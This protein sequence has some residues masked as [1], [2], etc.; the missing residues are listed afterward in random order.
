MKDSG[1]LSRLDPDALI[2]DAAALLRVP[3]VPAT[4]GRCSSGS[5]SWR[6]AGL[7][8]DLH[9][10]DLAAL[11]A[12]PD[13]PGE[14][15]PRDE[16]WGLTATLRR[17]ARRGRLC[18]NGHVDVVGPGTEPWRRGPWSGASRTGACTAAA[19]ST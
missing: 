4:S 17:A 13:H 11:R 5:P 12:H 14:E 19:R 1:A 2:G 15:A 10:H 18:L 8:A 3:S 9:E 7:A 16:L 6:R